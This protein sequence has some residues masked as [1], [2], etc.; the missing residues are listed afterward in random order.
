MKKL[1][2]IFI[3]ALSFTAYLAMCGNAYAPDHLANAGKMVIDPA[4]DYMALM[5]ETAVAGDHEAGEA[6]EVARSAKIDAMGLPMQKIAYED[7]YYLAK[8][9]QAEA[10]DVPG[11]AGDLVRMGIMCVVLNRVEADDFPGDTVREILE[12]PGQYYIGHPAYDYY[13]RTQ[14]TEAT[15]MLALRVLEGERVLGPEAVY[16]SNMPI[17]SYVVD[18]V[19]MGVY[20]TMFFSGR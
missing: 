2:A 13:E 20:G 9:A 14:P 19:D 16:H 15:A 10:G 5:I 7:L 1:I 18:S 3:T 4:P 11:E 12:A 6:A 8:I 17:G